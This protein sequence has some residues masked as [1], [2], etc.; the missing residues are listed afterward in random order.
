MKFQF[1]RK[2][3]GANE[4][5]DFARNTR[6]NGGLLSSLSSYQDSI[7]VTGCQRSGTTLVTRLLVQNPDINDIWVSKDDEYD[8]ALILS[9]SRHVSPSNRYCFQTTYLNEA[10]TEYID[11][12][13]IPF[14]IVWVLRNPYSVVNS[15][16]YNWS[17]YALNELFNA[18]G[19]KYLDKYSGHSNLT[20]NPLFGLKALEKAC[21]SYIGK[22][23]Q[24]FELVDHFSE[25]RLL[26]INYES[27][28]GNPQASVPKLF[29]YSNLN[30]NAD[31]INIIKGSTKPVDAI[32]NKNIIED[33]C[34]DTYKQARELAVI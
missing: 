26:V 17:R 25:D 1:V 14:Q 18:C 20:E 13:D 11:N 6:I 8:A 23:N 27:I 12:K 24:L 34:M 22:Q 19:E 3:F 31:Y 29:S 30:Y 7:L 33:L 15:M 2:Y 32:K 9:G 10:Y 5:K 4:W 28:T 21:L 16:L